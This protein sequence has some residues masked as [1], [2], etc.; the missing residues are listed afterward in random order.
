[1]VIDLLPALPPELPSGH[2]R[3]LVARPGIDVSIEWRRGRLLRAGL[4]ARHERAVGD[5]VVRYGDHSVLVHVERD[6]ELAL[7][8]PRLTGVGG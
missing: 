4:C 8:G 6:R 2:V 5:H 1:G 3:R 7:D